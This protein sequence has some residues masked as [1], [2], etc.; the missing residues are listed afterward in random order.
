MA[1]SN[2][3]FKRPNL[4]ESDEYAK[5]PPPPGQENSFVPPGKSQGPS[6]QQSGKSQPSANQPP[7]PPS[8]EEIG[9]A[10]QLEEN[11]Q[12]RGYKPNDAEMARYQDIAN[13]IV[14]FQQAQA[15][16]QAQAAAA[17]AAASISPKKKGK[18]W[19]FLKIMIFIAFV[20]GFWAKISVIVLEPSY[21]VP[22]GKVYFVIKPE[23]FSKVL[24]TINMDKIYDEK[25]KKGFKAEDLNLETEIPAKKGKGKKEINPNWYTDPQYLENNYVMVVPYIKL[26][27]NF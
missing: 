13:R 9:W 14:L 22:K 4:S 27:F 24:F 26:N 5:I 10:I 6:Q 16:R 19:R 25:L 2:Q 18:F 23:P 21:F 20:T 12:K 17:Q 3:P 1:Q 11:V 7:L 8:Q 15:Q